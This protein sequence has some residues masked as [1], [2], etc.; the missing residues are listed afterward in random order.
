MEKCS[1]DLTL[2]ELRI[3]LR[4]RFGPRLRLGPG[5]WPEFKKRASSAGLLLSSLN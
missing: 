1:L 5:P 2:Q 4:G 3:V